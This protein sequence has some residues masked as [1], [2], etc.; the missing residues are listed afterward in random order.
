M[1]K[2]EPNTFDTNDLGSL[3]E[4]ASFPGWLFPNSFSLYSSFAIITKNSSVW[5]ASSQTAEGAR[6]SSDR[7]R[8]APTAS[9]ADATTTWRLSRRRPHVRRPGQPRV[10][11]QCFIQRHRSSCS[12]V[13]DTAVSVTEPKVSEGLVFVS[14]QVL[15]H[16]MSWLMAV[17]DPNKV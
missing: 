5:S 15:G 13:P 4:D 7:L 11:M 3:I 12:S 9:A 10:V 1:T 16:L 2:Y 14:P 6:C 17:S 8:K